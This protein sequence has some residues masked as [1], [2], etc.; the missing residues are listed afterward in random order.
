VLFLILIVYKSKLFSFGV[1]LKHFLASIFYAHGLVYGQYPVVN[2]VAWSLEVEIQFYILA[3]VLTCVFA[4][5]SKFWRRS[6]LLIFI[7]VSGLFAGHV[8]SPLLRPSLTLLNFLQFFLAGFVLVDLYLTEDI[9]TLT[10][11]LWD[12]IGLTALAWIMLSQS[13]N[14]LIILPF[15]TLTLFLGGFKGKFVRGFFS[16]ALISAIGGMCYSLYL[17]H[18]AILSLMTPYVQRIARLPLFN[19]LQLI[20]IIIPCVIAVLISGS[21]FYLL[22]ERPCM[23]A[24]WPNRLAQKFCAGIR[25]RH[26]AVS[27]S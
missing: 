21:I 27:E 19:T 9:P 18:S 12:A 13:P 4:I 7:A 5:R 23:A 3:P 22:I 20:L 6:L 17:T 2:P 10:P 1:L 14:Y 26:N 8:I 11:L 15:V 25:T 16:S 24:D